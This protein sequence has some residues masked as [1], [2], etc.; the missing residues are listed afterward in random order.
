[1]FYVSHLESDMQTAALQSKETITESEWI[2]FLQR[3]RVRLYACLQVW[4]RKESADGLKANEENRKTSTV[5][6]KERCKVHLC[7]RLAL[8]VIDFHSQLRLS[9]A[10][11]ITHSKNYNL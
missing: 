11:S 1:M 2:D 3:E 7:G 8:Y 9:K 6:E 10:K 5:G 4:D